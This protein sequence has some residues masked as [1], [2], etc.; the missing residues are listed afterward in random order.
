MIS[1]GFEVDE[2]IGGFGHAYYCRVPALQRL[3]D[4]KTHVLLRHPIAG[5]TSYAI[6]VL[7]R[8]R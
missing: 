2:Y 5:L 4:A 8:P 6:L 1:V 3:E 7:R